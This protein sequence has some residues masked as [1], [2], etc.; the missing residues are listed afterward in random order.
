MK[1]RT[2]S[3][4]IYNWLIKLPAYYLIPLLLLAQLIVI[5]I[6]S[7]AGFEGTE[8]AGFK[9]MAAWKLV[10]LGCIA[11][12]LVETLA[13]QLA[14][15]E[16]I[17]YFNGKLKILAF[18]VSAILFG[19]SHN[20][21]F[22]YIALGMVMGFFYSLCYMICRDKKGRKYAYWSVVCMHTAWNTIGVVSLSIP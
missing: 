10:I 11:A 9:E 4:L 15:I 5:F 3:L 19:L 6:L 22:D 8:A 18:A 17:L 1:F 13:L 7:L 2:K 14:P 12:P 21:S 20:Y 16:I